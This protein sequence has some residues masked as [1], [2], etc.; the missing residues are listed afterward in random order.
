MFALTN[1]DQNVP[2]GSVKGSSPEAIP[3]RGTHLLLNTEPKKKKKKKQ[4]SNFFPLEY[5]RST[6]ISIT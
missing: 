6:I 5:L 1:S 2:S 4:H 3:S